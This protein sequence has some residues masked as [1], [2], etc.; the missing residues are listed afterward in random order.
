MKTITIL[1]FCLITFTSFSQ[2][3]NYTPTFVCNL[4]DTTLESSGLI[5]INKTLWTHN[6]SGGKPELYQLDTLTGFVKRTVKIKNTTNID[7]E[8]LAQS[9]THIFV[10]DFGNNYGN[11]TNLRIFR[12]SKLDLLNPLNDSIIADTIK[13]HYQDQSTFTSTLNANNYDCEAFVFKNDSLHLFSKS[14]ITQNTKHYILPATIGN[15]IAILSDSFNV[16]GLIT[17]ADINQINGNLVLLGYKKVGF[18]YNCF[19]WLLF[20]YTNRNFFKADKRRLELGVASTL[21]QTEG[22]VIKNDNTGY[23]SSE[24][25]VTSFG[26]ILPQLYKFNFNSYFN[27]TNLNEINKNLNYKVFPNPAKEK[28]IIDLPN[29]ETPFTLELFNING[30]NVYIDQIKDINQKEIN[31]KK[32]GSGIYFLKIQNE[33]TIFSQKII[34]E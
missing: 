5:Y 14:W 18:N 32:I 7:W 1:F 11:R 33:S 15:H 27:T 13:F 9:A 10:G 25:I 30:E 26:T 22:I 31:L 19:A 8:D 20:N 12:I 23:F 21:G 3:I 17:S 2:V 28:L 24:K 6:D 34:I 29:S 4:S 16:D